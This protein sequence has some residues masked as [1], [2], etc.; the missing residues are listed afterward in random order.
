M[1]GQNNKYPHQIFKRS[2]P[3]DRRTKKGFYEP[4]RQGGNRKSPKAREAG[5]TGEVR[6]KTMLENG[7]EVEGNSNSDGRQGVGRCCRPRESDSV[8]N[9]VPV[10][11]CG[12]RLRRHGRTLH[13]QLPT[14]PGRV[15][16]R[17]MGARIPQCLTALV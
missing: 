16:D 5:R 6:Q 9:D 8:P 7:T 2:R 13:P 14:R 1:R 12:V 10:K 17:R 3:V 11:V 4:W 15:V